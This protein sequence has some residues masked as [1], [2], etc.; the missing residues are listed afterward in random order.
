MD[1]YTHTHDDN[2]A[3]LLKSEKITS[4]LDLLI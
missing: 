2:I 3:K 1:L 4:N